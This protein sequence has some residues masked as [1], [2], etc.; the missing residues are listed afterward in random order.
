MLLTDTV[1]KNLNPRDSA[2]KMSDRDELYLPVSPSGS[3]LWR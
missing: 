3:K 1:L 2:Y